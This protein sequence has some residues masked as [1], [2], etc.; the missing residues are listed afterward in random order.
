MP[1][2]HLISPYH[3]PAH[4][5]AIAHEW[6]LKMERQKEKKRQEWH[7]RRRA[8]WFWEQKPSVYQ[9]PTPYGPQPAPYDP[10]GIGVMG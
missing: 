10:G 6:V 1:S 2:K 7:A 9:H 3:S 4:N 8:L 5:I